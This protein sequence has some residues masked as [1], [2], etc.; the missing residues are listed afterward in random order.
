M[1]L[2]NFTI[3]AQEAVQSAVNTCREHGAAEQSA[4]H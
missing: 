3:K 4:G 2:E 1:T